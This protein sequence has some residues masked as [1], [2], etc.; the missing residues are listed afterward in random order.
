MNIEENRVFPLRSAYTFATAQGLDAQA[1]EIREM[2]IEWDRNYTSTVRRGRFIRLF[3]NHSV[4]PK[5]IAQ[6][7]PIGNTAKGEASKRAAL[8]VAQEYDDF[9]SGGTDSE[10][11]EEENALVEMK[12]F[13]FALEAHL[14]DFL[15]RNLSQIEPGLRLFE[16]EGRTGIEY[17][18]DG[19]RIDLLA[20]DRDGHPV[21][22]ELKLAQG[23]NKALGQLLYYMGW[24]DQ[25]LNCGPCR[26]VVI[27]S[28]ISTEL[29]VAV[30]R[31]PGVAL[32]RYKMNFSLEQSGGRA[33]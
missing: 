10:T 23:R 7:W 22:I 5:F 18:V 1:V 2:E 33:A 13:E 31:V 8:R 12:S 19:G 21:V 16:A 9:L 14:R 3:E 6:F 27:A 20:L 28:D 32:Y 15:A 30:S 17:P 4:M 29:T 25:H 11:E 26:G 24:V